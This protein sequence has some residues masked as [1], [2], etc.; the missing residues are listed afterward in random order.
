MIIWLSASPAYH[1][2]PELN[3]C[4]YCCWPEFSVAQPSAWLRVSTEYTLIN[5][6]IN[7]LFICLCVFLHLWIECSWGRT[8]SPLGPESV[9]WYLP[10][11]MCSDTVFW[12]T[13]YSISM[14]WILQ[15]WPVIV[16]LWSQKVTK[17]R[18]CPWRKWAPMKM[19]LWY[20][21]PSFIAFFHRGQSSYP[22][23][24]LSEWP[25]LLLTFHLEAFFP[26]NFIIITFLRL[27]LFH[28]K[29]SALPLGP[30]FALILST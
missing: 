26:D 8:L 21:L 16:V 5:E 13:S 25:F 23:R 3:K 11:G 29:P 30:W 14:S 28:T 9:S 19:S 2:C 7:V 12:I 27:L 24:I 20:N 4:F 6:W 15:V 10:H 22:C 18:D 1:T 17:T